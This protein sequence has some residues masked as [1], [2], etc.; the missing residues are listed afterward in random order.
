M[1]RIERL[2]GSSWMAVMTVA[3]EKTANV[4]FAHLVTWHGVGAIRVV[5]TNK[6][7]QS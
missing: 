7:V 4:Y 5:P 6:S 2:H 1:Y 3:N